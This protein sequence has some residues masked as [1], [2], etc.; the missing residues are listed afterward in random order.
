MQTRLFKSMML[1]LGVVGGSIAVAQGLPNAPP[2]PPGVLLKSPGQSSIDVPTSSIQSPVK[3]NPPSQSAKS[4]HGNQSGGVRQ[5]GVA[6]NHLSSTHE[7][8]AMI[9]AK[10][11]TAEAKTELF[12]KEAAERQARR[13]EQ[14]EIFELDKKLNKPIWKNG[15]GGFGLGKDSAKPI[16]QISS[17]YSIHGF[18][19]SLT[20]EI[21]IEGMPSLITARVGTRWRGNK[22]TEITQNSVSFEDKDGE[23]NIIWTT[24]GKSASDRLKGRSGSGFQV[25]PPGPMMPNMGLGPPVQPTMPQIQPQ[26][27]VSSS[28]SKSSNLLPPLPSAR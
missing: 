15:E 8:L 24:I 11:L 3:A 7:E 12:N 18:G 26:S 17:V 10:I 16:D 13:K 4:A 6:L 19:E 5:R 22:V 21:Y 1:L 14:E 28:V 25:A 20:A 27:Q 9:R 23:E 2:S